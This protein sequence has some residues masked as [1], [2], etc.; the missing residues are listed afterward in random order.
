[1]SEENVEIVRALQP[2]GA[3][4]ATAAEGDQEPFP[5]VDASRFAADFA[6]TFIAPGLTSDTRHGIAGF[7]EG[8]RDWLEPWQ[9]YEIRAEDFIDAGDAVVVFAR[10]HALTRR[11]AMEIE[12][13]PAAV[14]A[15]RD[16]IVCQIDFY[17]ER[18]EALKAVG[19]EE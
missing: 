11:D 4:L 14:W 1:M 7:M 13:A 9:R 16:G 6:S 19:L 12:H 18:G 5:G 15:L 17:Y 3:D 8:W 10:V 2:S